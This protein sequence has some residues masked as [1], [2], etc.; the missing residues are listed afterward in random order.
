MKKPVFQEATE[1]ETHVARS[2]S[3]HTM[4]VRLQ[5]DA[6]PK[7]PRWVKAMVIVAIVLFVLFLI[8]RVTVIPYLHSL[9]G[10]V[11][12]DSQTPF[13]S[14]LIHGGQWV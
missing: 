13:V 5:H 9:S 6:P 14:L 10:H 12:F 1:E 2:L 8:L 7:V 4:R 3:N 11:G